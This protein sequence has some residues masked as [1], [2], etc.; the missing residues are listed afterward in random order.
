MTTPTPTEE[1]TYGAVTKQIKDHLIP[2]NAVIALCLTLWAVIDFASPVLGVPGLLLLAGVMALGAAVCFWRM[3]VEPVPQRLKA[4][5]FGL[6]LLLLGLGSASATLRVEQ[7]GWIASSFGKVRDVQTV[8]FDLQTQVA[9]VQQGVDQANQTLNRID[10]RTEAM[11]GPGA[12]CADYMCLLFQNA[13]VQRY[14]AVKAMGVD[15]RTVPLPLLIRLAETPAPNSFDAIRFFLDA[16]VP[17]DINQ[18]FLEFRWGMVINPQALVKPPQRKAMAV[19]AMARQMR[20]GPDR[21]GDVEALFDSCAVYPEKARW[22]E[23]AALHDNRTLVKQLLAEGADPTLRMPFC[24]KFR[25]EAKRPYA[26]TDKIRD[27]LARAPDLHLTAQE[28][29]SE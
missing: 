7:G 14:A 11:T 24:T 5:G 12:A 26:S 19:R 3:P 29:I 18:P 13:P 25:E 28:F 8:L 1:S 21:M 10:E 17:A 6:L 2:L 22:L 15:P 4:T 16:G 20:V 23:V 27:L 9:R